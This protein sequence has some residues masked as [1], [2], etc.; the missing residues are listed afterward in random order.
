[1]KNIFRFLLV[2]LCWILIVETSHAREQIRPGT[3]SVTT[4]KATAAGCEPG[5]AYRYLDINNVR[6]LCYSY[7]NGWFLENAEYEI[8][9]GSRKTSLFSFS[10]WIG[11]IDINNNLKLAAYKFGQGPGIAAAH[12][13]ND[14]WPGPLT[15]DG[16]A[17]IDPETCAKYDKLF[18]MTR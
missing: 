15:T 2:T 6:T 10:L 14:Y 7:G 11:G 3:K 18:L 4:L 12:T 13:K 17:A 1:M 9:K 5:S 16:T 8:P